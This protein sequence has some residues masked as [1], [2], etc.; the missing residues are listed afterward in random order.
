MNINT[1]NT[2]PDS[3]N[4][5]ALNTTTTTIKGQADPNSPAPPFCVFS[6]DNTQCTLSFLW[7]TK[8]NHNALYN[9]QCNRIGYK[10]NITNDGDFSMDS[11]LP[12]VAV[13]NTME[14]IWNYAGE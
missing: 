14:W 11:E 2:T 12:Y 3:D 4:I 13:G 10:P 5:S 6:S 1:L 8:T 9:H 7:L